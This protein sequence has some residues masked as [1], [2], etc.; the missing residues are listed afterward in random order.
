MTRRLL[1]VSEAAEL[2]G[3]SEK[4][5]YR[6]ISEGSFDTVDISA[7]SSTRS[8]TRIPED[9]LQAWIRARTSQRTA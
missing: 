1:R 5:V 2:I 7:A 3:C 4:T 8:K 6:L 9:S